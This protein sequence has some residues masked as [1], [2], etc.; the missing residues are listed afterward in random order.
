MSDA[1]RVRANGGYRF[2]GFSKGFVRKP[3]AAEREITIEKAKLRVVLDRRLGRTTPDSVKKLA[4]Q[5]S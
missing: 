2:K 1:A 4:Q 5:D 3:S